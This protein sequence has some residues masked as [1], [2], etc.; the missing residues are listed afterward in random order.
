ML[1]AVFLYVRFPVS[2]HDLQEILAGRGIAVDH[3]TLNRWV[4]RYSPQ[5]AVQV[6]M[7]NGARQSRRGLKQRLILATPKRTEGDL[8]G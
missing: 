8:S 1:D 5:I 6:H 4:V 2:Y 3:P 7:R